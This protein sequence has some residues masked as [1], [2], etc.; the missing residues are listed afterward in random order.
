VRR[1]RQRDSRGLIEALRNSYDMGEPFAAAVRAARLPMVIADPAQDDH[2]VVFANQAFQHLTGY[3][4]DEIIGRNCRFLQGPETSKADI[5]KV[6]QAIEAGDSIAVDLLNYRKDG[7]PFWNA[8]IMSPV[9]GDDN[10]IKFFFA[11]QLDITGR[12]EA[13][14]ALSQERQAI[15]REV[16]QRTT[17]LQAAL[18][19]K[20]LLLHEVDHRVKNNLMMIGSLVRLQARKAGDPQLRAALQTMLNRIDALASV[21]RRLYQSDDVTVF[22]IGEFAASLTSEIVLASDHAGTIVKTE[23]EPVLIPAKKAG[24]LG[25]MLNEIVTNAV[26]HAFGDGRAGSLTLTVQKSGNTARI[27]ICDDGPGIDLGKPQPE[28]LGWML[29]HRLARQIGATVTKENAHPGTCV[30]LSLEV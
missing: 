3:A 26:K 10:R 17:E 6:R 11:S 14:A 2:P 22:D 9:K 19:A 7:S 8:M 18:E 12:V 4:Q 28:G 25:L 16:R 5:A 13:Q 20:T 23:V 1:M 30:T 21:H 15:E 24:P 27:Q 29:I